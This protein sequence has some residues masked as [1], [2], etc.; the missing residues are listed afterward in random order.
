[1]ESLNKAKKENLEIIQVD[2]EI[3]KKI[4]ENVADV[5]EDHDKNLSVKK[6]Y[7]GYDCFLFDDGRGGSALTKEATSYA[8]FS[9]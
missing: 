2:H 8:M 4:V 5:S 7:V 1:M 6:S 9:L 3:F